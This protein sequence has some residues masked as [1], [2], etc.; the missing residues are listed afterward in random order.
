MQWKQSTVK[1]CIYLIGN[2][3][4]RSIKCAKPA[5]NIWRI[6]YYLPLVAQGSIIMWWAYVTC[7]VTVGHR[8]R[9]T[10]V[11]RLPRWRRRKTRL[12]VRP[13]LTMLQDMDRCNFLHATR[14]WIGRTC[15]T[16]I[17]GHRASGWSSG[18]LAFF[19]GGRVT[20]SKE[21]SDWRLGGG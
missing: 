21:A 9:V 16:G 2:T 8:R 11:T 3:V 20:W 15:G 14:Y 4:W 10:A 18:A 19:G 5:Y 6:W 17:S 12:Q 1:A 13:H 7:V